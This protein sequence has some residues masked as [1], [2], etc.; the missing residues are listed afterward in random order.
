MTDQYKIVN[1]SAE[2]EDCRECGCKRFTIGQTT[3]LNFLRLECAK[4]SHFHNDHDAEAQL[5]KLNPF[6]LISEALEEAGA[7]LLHTLTN[8]TDE[9]EASI[10]ADLWKLNDKRLIVCSYLDTY[11]IYQ[12]V[13]EPRDS[14]EK[15]LEFIKL[16]AFTSPT[17]GSPL[18]SRSV[19]ELMD[20]SRRHGE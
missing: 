11:G 4:C 6:E 10:E 19:E 17:T 12:F 20:F 7:E 18:S 15:D 2:V 3:A 16:L 8:E 9:L 14:V 13:G 1:K 5:E